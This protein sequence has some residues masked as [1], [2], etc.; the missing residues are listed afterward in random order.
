MVI[1]YKF[2]KNEILIQPPGEP[3]EYHPGEVRPNC[4]CYKIFREKKM[5]EW[6]NKL[7]RIFEKSTKKLKIKS[8]A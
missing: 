6:V 7:W 5:T 1:I 3:R 2:Y 8:Q 4:S